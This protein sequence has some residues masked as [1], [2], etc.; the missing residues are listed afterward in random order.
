MLLTIVSKTAFPN[1]NISH[2]TSTNYLSDFN[3]SNLQKN[4]ILQA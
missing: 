3:L 2:Y 1:F 4:Y